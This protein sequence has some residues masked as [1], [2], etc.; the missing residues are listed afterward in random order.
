M[1]N[2]IDINTARWLTFKEARMYSRLGEKKL[3]E[4]LKRGVIYGKR[5]DG[6]WIVDRE[7][8]DSFYES[9]RFEAEVFME[10]LN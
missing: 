10:G 3:R 8:I 2:A 7:S 4:L 5:L 1:R 9:D 6:K